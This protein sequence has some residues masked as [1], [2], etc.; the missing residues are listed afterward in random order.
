MIQSRKLSALALVADYDH[1][2]SCKTQ[3]SPYRHVN[4][5]KN[6]KF[7]I[8]II[9]VDMALKGKHGK[10]LHSKFVYI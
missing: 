9:G 7:I 6:F 1:Y 8:V 5:V 2:M 10:Y 4:K 3:K